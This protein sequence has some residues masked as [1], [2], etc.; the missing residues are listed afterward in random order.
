MLRSSPGK[1]YLLFHFLLFPCCFFFSSFFLFLAPAVLLL[2]FPPYPLPLVC[3]TLVLLSS[4]LL[5]S[6]YSPFQGQQKLL[7]PLFLLV[8][9]ELLYRLLSETSFLLVACCA[10]YL[11]FACYLLSIPCRW[12]QCCPTKHLKVNVWQITQC[13]ML[14]GSNLYNHQHENLKSNTV[15]TLLKKHN[16]SLMVAVQGPDF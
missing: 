5:P 9:P 14:S 1:F 15:V 16:R 13:H 4:H 8:L 6:P 10:C 12:K 7:F 11:L 2:L 3:S